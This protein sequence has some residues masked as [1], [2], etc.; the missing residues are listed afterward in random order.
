MRA[1]L[2]VLVLLATAA[3]ADQPRPMT[4]VDLLSVPIQSDVRLAPGGKTAL[5]VRTQPDWDQDKL[6]SHIWKVGADG[7]GAARM[8]N[9]TT[10]ERSPRWSPDGNRFCFVATRGGEAA[11]LFVQSFAGG[12][13]IQVSSHETSVSDPEW[14]PGGTRIAFIAEDPDSK[15]TRDAKEHSGEVV[16][17]D[18]DYRQKHLW[19]FDLASKTE[20]RVTGGSFSVLEYSVSA[21]GSTLVY[22][23]APT[24]LVDDGNR[25][26]IFIR[27]L[28]G[29][30]ARRLTDNQVEERGATLSPDRKT[31][32][33]IAGTDERFEPYYQDHLF[34]VPAAGGTP[35]ML[36]RDVTDE[37]EAADWSRDGKALVVRLT[38]GVRV[39]LW[40]LDPTS[41]RRSHLTDGDSTVVSEHID[42][43]SGAWAAVIRGASNPGDVWIASSVSAPP[44]CVTGFGED[45]LARFRMPKTEVV[46]WTGRDG[47]KVEGLL[48]YP[49]DYVPGTRAPL[50]VQ[51]HG[52][53]M[54]SSRFG[55]PD[56]ED[57]KPVLAARGYMVLDPNYRGSSGYGDAFLRDM[58]GHYFH[59]ADKDVLAGVDALIERGLADPEKLVA[60]GWSAGGHMTNWLVTTTTRFKAAASGA[61]ATN[62]ISMYGQSDVRT[63]RAPWFG[64]TPWGKNAPLGLYLE[65]SPV[66]HV[67]GAKTPTLLLVGEKDVRVP[68][69]Q[70][71]EML[72]ALRGSGVEADLLVF[73][74]EPHTLKT[75]KHQLH[76]VNSEIAWFERHLFGR[77]YEMEKP[78]GIKNDSKTDT[79]KQ[80]APSDARPT[81][82][83]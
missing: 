36:L 51:T 11:Q 39:H 32:A 21:D 3:A 52:G 8:T 68:T 15:E 58:V 30:E 44:T 60:M 17:Y 79:E 64:G 13:A 80:Q 9:G 45:V 20:T 50:V 46:T 41:G 42:P 18:R 72:R 23:A 33:F 57:Y 48:T 19:V 35:H 77:T 59:E 2:V 24:P 38:S 83:R 54:W 29:G 49:L 67:A 82:A 37:A 70:S 65:Q 69:A 81:A 61:G 12:E 66:A 71:I 40:T 4:A 34:L 76:K 1:R 25:A 47:Q 43:V 55:F 62:W 28:A 73:P 14:L 16:S 56:W 27:P 74:G 22:V 6:V 31:I 10:G 5:F 78:P 63:Y 53:P 26:E 7:S 75:L